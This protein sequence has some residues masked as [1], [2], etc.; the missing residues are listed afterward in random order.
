MQGK[1]NVLNYNK[2]S[3]SQRRNRLQ[4]MKVQEVLVMTDIHKNITKDLL[5]VQSKSNCES[6]S[7]AHT[8]FRLKFRSNPL[9]RFFLSRLDFNTV[10][11]HPD[12][13]YILCQD[14]CLLF[15]GKCNHRWLSFFY[16]HD[17]FA[18]FFATTFV[19]TIENCSEYI[20]WSHLGRWVFWCFG[21]GSK[22]FDEI[23]EI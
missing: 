1:V 12:K 14:R 9:W 13:D 18:F 23:I 15:W 16:W 22:F 8:W 20:S 4:E 3:L 19:L 17:S 11:C 10:L 21:Q 2:L 5:I 6:R 7:Q